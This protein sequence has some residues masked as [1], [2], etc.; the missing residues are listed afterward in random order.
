MQRIRIAHACL[1][2]AFCFSLGRMTLQSART[3]TPAFRSLDSSTTGTDDHARSLQCY[4]RTMCPSVL[5]GSRFSADY[6]TFFDA[7]G[8]DKTRYSFH[9]YLSQNSSVIEV[10]GYT[11]VD[12]KKMR[13]MHGPF[14]TLLFE[15]IFYDEARMNLKG[16]GVEVYPYGL[17][18]STRSAT[19]DIK[20]DST[21]PTKDGQV[22][23][24]RRFSDVIEELSIV[25][26]DLLQINCEGCEWEVLESV[27]DDK[28]THIFQHIQVQFH[29]SADWVE[30][31]LDRYAAIQDRLTETHELLY[32]HP[33]I[34]QLW[35]AKST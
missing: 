20:G 11:G 6:T 5:R 26:I 24:I 34:W 21:R 23:Q 17:G 7:F 13:Q 2:C 8:G 25:R 27:I 14:K 9:T 32:D 22:A 28:Q 35:Q 4:A 31:R 1:L 29:P 18:A 3:L 10:G 19:F 12:I 30:D 16:L 15:P 33:W